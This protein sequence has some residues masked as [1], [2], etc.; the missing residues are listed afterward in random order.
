VAATLLD[1]A[2]EHPNERFGAFILPI[3]AAAVIP[4]WDLAMEP[5][6]ATIAKAWIWH[7]GGAVF[8]VP[9]LDHLRWSMTSW[10]FFQAFA[11]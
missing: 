8:G 9:L 4:Q 7:Q 3:V 6:K 1:G 5:P 2:D 11:V 10:L